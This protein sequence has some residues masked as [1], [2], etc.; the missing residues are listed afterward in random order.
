MHAVSKNVRFGILL[1]AL[2]ILLGVGAYLV[3]SLYSFVPIESPETE[4]SVFYNA[5]AN[6]FLS[7]LEHFKTVDVAEVVVDS[8]PV[9]I[10]ISA[11]QVFFLSGQDK[12]VEELASAI[13]S[14]KDVECIFT[15]TK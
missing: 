4:E 11:N 2:L 8:N 5:S 10:N 12:Y 9:Q 13:F 6:F 7:A 14:P 3:T 15:V 1:F